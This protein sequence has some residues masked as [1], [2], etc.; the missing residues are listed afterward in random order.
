MM[1]DLSYLAEN[2]PWPTSQLSGGR[3]AD[4]SVAHTAPGS[5]SAGADED[6]LDQQPLTVPAVHERTTL[7]DGNEA[8]N[9]HR[10]TEDGG[11]AWRRTAG[12]SF[13]NTHG[14]EGTRQA[15]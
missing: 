7:N 11:D 4:P 6:D 2:S 14:P 3:P 1:Q 12:R 8:P 5:S 10:F 9:P 13:V 15:L